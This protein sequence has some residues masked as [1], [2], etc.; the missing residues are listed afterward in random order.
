MDVSG[1]GNLII[2]TFGVQFVGNTFQVHIG[3]SWI[4]CLEKC[5]AIRKCQWVNYYPRMSGLCELFAVD[6]N[7]YPSEE[8]RESVWFSFKS[9]WEYDEPT[10]CKTCSNS[11]LCTSDERLKCNIVACPHII[12][13]AGAK[14]LGN[15][16]NVGATRL[17]V[18]GNHKQR[19]V[20]CLEDG[21]WSNT[22]N[23]N[24]ICTLPNI[25]HGSLDVTEFENGMEATIVCDSGYAHLGV[26]KAQCDEISEERTTLKRSACVKLQDES[27]TFVYG[28]IH[29][30]ADGVLESWE[31]ERT[32]TGD[33]RNNDILSALNEHNINQIKVELI[34]FSD[35]VAASLI[36]DGTDRDV[37]SWFSQYKLV[38]SSWTHLTTGGVSAG[39]FDITGMTAKV[40]DARQDIVDQKITLRWG[41]LDYDSESNKSKK[42]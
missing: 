24:C 39:V 31:K 9:N 29:G 1:L 3:I 28:K 6:D 41:I 10:H 15:R 14:I 40:A 30:T 19:L 22:T 36:F 38:E 5:E 25:N 35:N 21:S 17:Y 42:K 7:K 8:P 2:P 27:W 11:Q 37:K 23:I 12:P 33:Y 26:N 4:R 34:D 20:T 16:N 13:A 18:C 32:G